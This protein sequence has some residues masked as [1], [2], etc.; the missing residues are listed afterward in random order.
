MAWDNLA[1]GDGLL[2]LSLK[3][4]DYVRTLEGCPENV[5]ESIRS[6]P[7]TAEPGVNISG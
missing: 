7:C 3:L 6:R 5:D 1:V 2:Q 4:R